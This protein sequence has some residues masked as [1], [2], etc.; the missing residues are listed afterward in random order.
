MQIDRIGGLSGSIAIKVPCRVATTAN[1]VLSGL[2]T[3][4]GVALAA[5]DRVLVKNQTTGSENGIYIAATGT[6]TRSPDFDGSRDVAKGTLVGATDGTVA[7]GQLFTVTTADPITIGTTAL[8]FALHSVNSALGVTNTPAGNI[9]ATSVQ[10]A[11]NELDA[12]KAPVDSRSTV[13]QHAT[14]MDLWALGSII[15]GT[16]SAVTITAIVNAPQAGARRVFYPLVG[17]ILTHGATFDIAGNENVTAAAGDSW[18]FI[19]KTTSTYSVQVVKDSGTGAFRSLQVFT[20]SGTYTPTAGMTRCQVTVV[21]GGGGGGGSATGTASAGGG[22]AGG[23]A[24]IGMFTAAQIGASQAVTIPAAAAGGAA[25]SAGATGGTVSLGALISATGGVGG[26]VGGVASD[27]VL[28]GIGT[29][30]SLNIRGGSAPVGNSGATFGP[31]GGGS[32]LLGAGAPS[33]LTAANAV[34]L[35]GGAYGGG[36]GGGVYNTASSAGGTGAQGVII[37]EEFF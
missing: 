27:G 33:R 4:D 19:A 35:S 36:G 29:G 22:G 6:W 34:G 12:E 5:A 1:I 37:I 2:Q 8:T 25:G 23:G 15:D 21:G 11:L 28:G 31:N 18:E 30:G 20:A 9:T 17:T 26:P 14:T 24:A 10:A 16:G 7:A 3:I 13:T 32:S